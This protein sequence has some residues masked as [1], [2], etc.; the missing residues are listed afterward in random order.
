MVGGWLAAAVVKLPAKMPAKKLDHPF[1]LIVALS[2]VGEEGVVATSFAVSRL[3]RFP[4]RSQAHLEFT[5]QAELR[6]LS[7]AI[8]GAMHDQ[9]RHLEL[10]GAIPGSERITRRMKNSGLYVAAGQ[11]VLLRCA[12]AARVPDEREPISAGAW[13]RARRPHQG[14]DELHGFWIL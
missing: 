4:V 6:V 8:R 13:Q 12:A 3:D 7:E 5:R 10:R 14:A 11:K 2:R 9:D 1:Q